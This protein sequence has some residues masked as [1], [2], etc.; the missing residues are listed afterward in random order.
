MVAFIVVFV[1][2]V[3]CQNLKAVIGREQQKKMKKVWDSQKRYE[4]IACTGWSRVRAPLSTAKLGKA[5]QNLEVYLKISDE[6]PLIAKKRK[7]N[8]QIL[9]FGCGSKCATQIS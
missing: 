6:N 2:V 1:V 7:T 3:T 4:V 9:G 5:I 8:N